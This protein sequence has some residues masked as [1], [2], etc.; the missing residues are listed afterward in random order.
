MKE[1]GKLTKTVK[2]SRHVD[3]SLRLHRLLSAA[4]L[5]CECRTK[6][7]AALDRFALLENR[8]QLRNGLKEARHRR[9]LIADQLSYLADIDDITEN[10][11]DLSVFNEMALLF[12]EIANQADKAAD[13][14]R[15]IEAFTIQKMNGRFG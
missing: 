1:S 2:S 7:D 8:R 5:D 6:L 9:N 13:V 11:S 15:E 3:L 14:L 10:E 12:D 4:E